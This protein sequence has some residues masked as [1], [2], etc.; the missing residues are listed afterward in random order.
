MIVTVWTTIV[1][2]MLV[3]H[4]LEHLVFLS[5]NKKKTQTMNTAAWHDNFY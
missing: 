4:I 3:T 1:S 5:N 2:L